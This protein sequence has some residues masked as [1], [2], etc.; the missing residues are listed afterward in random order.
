M[1][2]ALHDDL[3]E[4]LGACLS[5]RDLATVAM[6]SRACRDV[7]R[8][9][10]ERRDALRVSHWR[11]AEVAAAYPL[12]RGL[13][14][15]G[16]PRRYGRA[17]AA[18]IADLALPGM[19][20]LRSLELHHPRLPGGGFWPLVFDRCPRLAHVRFVADFFMA[21]YVA[22]VRH[23]MDLVA[24]GAPRLTS[25][26]IEGGWLVIRR[27]YEPAENP[28]LARAVRLAATLPPVRSTTLR[29]LRHACRQVPLGVDAPVTH[30]TVDE[31]NE[32]PLLLGGRMGPTTTASVTD[33][34]WRASW[35]G[36]DAGVLAG[37]TALRTA[38][39]GVLASTPFRL[40][41]CL[42]TLCG[43]PAGLRRLTLDLDTW[44][45]QSGGS[46]VCWPTTA[47]A[48]LGHLEHLELRL[49]FPPD[50]ATTLLGSWLGAG[51]SVRQ[52]VLRCREPAVRCLEREIDRLREDEDAGTDDEAVQELTHAW[53]LASRPI[54]GY[55]L[56]VWLDT[57]P[58]AT[59]TVHNFGTLRCTHPRC[60]LL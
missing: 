43:L 13:N 27:V 49:P 40:T 35:P 24:H 2:E 7:A 14:V 21:N 51:P 54:Y 28:E 58:A 46:Y 19:P 52:V 47:L 31:Q 44:P 55:A 18:A 50:T 57:R 25:L 36:F 9:T 41:R 11:V 60:R 20:A 8:R 39:V 53:E 56:A 26:D 29:V 12:A 15:R 59:A 17:A 48:H 16:M 34:T 5:Q 42:S 23:V 3:W 10:M 33:L 1:L 30:L 6:C 37:M 38:T 4:R 22:D 45:M 32:P